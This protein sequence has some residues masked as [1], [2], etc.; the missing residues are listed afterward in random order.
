MI[1]GIQCEAKASALYQLTTLL[2]TLT[3][4]IETGGPCY[5]Y[6]LLDLAQVES[7]PWTNDNSLTNADLTGYN[8]F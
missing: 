1:E 4:S 8:T 5:L 6:L 7:L 3:N 2:I